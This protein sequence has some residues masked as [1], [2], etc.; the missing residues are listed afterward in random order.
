MRHWQYEIEIALQRKM[1]YE[2]KQ[3]LEAKVKLYEDKFGPLDIPPAD[4]SKS[5]VVNEN[6]ESTKV[7][8]K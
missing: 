5:D 4:I 1:I 2:L 7:E 8:Q 6:T 3:G